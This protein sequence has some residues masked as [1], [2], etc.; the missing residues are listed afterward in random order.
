MIPLIVALFK[1]STCIIVAEASGQEQQPHYTKQRFLTGSSGSSAASKKGLIG[2]LLLI[3]LVLA[4]FNIGAAYYNN[5][6]STADRNHDGDTVC[7]ELEAST[8]LE[9]GRSLKDVTETAVVETV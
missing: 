6:I 4:A 8:T 1:L 5:L 2:V 3:A 7:S 9:K